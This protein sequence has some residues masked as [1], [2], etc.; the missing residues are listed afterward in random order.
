ML[1]AAEQRITAMMVS[2]TNANKDKCVVSQTA[3]SPSTARVEMPSVDHLPASTS[4][5]TQLP[6]LFAPVTF[7]FK[8]RES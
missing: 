4:Q 2:S 5:K 8:G 6:L 1:A 3:L 7:S